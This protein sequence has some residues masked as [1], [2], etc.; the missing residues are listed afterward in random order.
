MDPDLHSAGVSNLPGD[1]GEFI[2]RLLERVVAGDGS[3]ADEAAL[4]AWVGDDPDRQRKIERLRAQWGAI[5]QAHD[6]DAGWARMTRHLRPAIS[7]EQA[8]P[9]P[10]ARRPARPL[11][12]VPVSRRRPL[13]AAAAAVAAAAVVAAAVW[14]GKSSGPTS[15][16][17]ASRVYTTSVGQRAD[18]RLS[19]GTHVLIA[20]ES[21]VRVATDF[22]IQRRDVYVEGEAYFE[23]VHDSRRPF[24]VFAAN[25]STVDVGTAFTVRNY[26]EERAVRVVVTEGKVVMS[27]AG[28]LARG[29]VGRLTADGRA[30]V[31]H[32]ADVSAFV[33]WT[34]GELVFED[35]PLGQVLEDLRRWY[36]IEARVA[37]STLATLPYTGSLRGITPLQGVELVAATLGLRLTRDD[38]R[39]VLEKR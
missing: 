7:T 8:E 9:M 22:G 12:V 25:T 21:R 15:E 31:R 20:P 13:H 23:V 6:V 17:A 19:D 28:P 16:F 30:S 32:G 37:D 34:R 18:I 4:A 29:D 14:F 5:H 35:A 33:G 36:G 1:E 38:G 3:P 26:A 39:I 10:I 11:A 2:L 24:T 27:G